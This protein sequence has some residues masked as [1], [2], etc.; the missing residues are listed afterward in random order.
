MG[1][2]DSRA[3]SA[4]N[5]DA[6]NILTVEPPSGVFVSVVDTKEWGKQYTVSDS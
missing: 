3:S 2:A 4:G 6:I 1:N 5:N